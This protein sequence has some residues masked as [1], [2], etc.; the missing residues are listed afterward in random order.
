MKIQELVEQQQLHELDVGQGIGKA[1]GGVAKGIGA[2]AGG[3]AGIP[4]AVKKGYRAGKAAVGGDDTTQPATGTASSGAGQFSAPST[5]PVTIRDQIRQYQ[6]AIS[7][8]QQQLSAPA[9]DNEEEPAEPAP[10]AS[11]VRPFVR[12]TQPT[13]VATPAAG[14]NWDAE[15][16]EPLSAKAKAEYQ[17]FSPE[18]KAEIQQNIKNKTPAAP[19]TTSADQSTPVDA[20]DQTPEEKRKADLAA[21]ADVAQQDMAANPVPSQQTSTATAPQTPEQIRQAKQ[22]TAAQVAQD[23]MGPQGQPIAQPTTTPAPSG[24]G[25]AGDIRPG[26]PQPDPKAQQTA[27]K[28]RLQ[29]G[30]TLSSRTSG[31]FK[32]SEVGAQ[33]NKLITKPDG[34]SQMVP[35]REG[36]VYSR[37][38]RSMI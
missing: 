13:N 11:N 34:S 24:L 9:A 36:K 21:A 30:D 26:T 32:D 16:G 17:A 2:V 3:I 10:S 1:V 23:Q 8:L 7:Q 5:N 18:Q 31:K 35:V 28:A 14:P 25:A 37:F 33:R 4:G 12:T 22:A 27:L 20:V 38:F 15:T 6:S 29:S 19:A